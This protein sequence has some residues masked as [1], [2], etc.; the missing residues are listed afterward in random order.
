MI[1]PPSVEPSTTYIDPNASGELRIGGTLRPTA[2]CGK[3]RSIIPSACRSSLSSSILR[4]D[5]KDLGRQGQP[6]HEAP[7]QC[8][9]HK[10]VRAARS[11][12]SSNSSALRDRMLARRAREQMPSP[13]SDA[14]V[15]SPNSLRLSR[16]GDGGYGL[17]RVGLCGVVH[18]RRHRN[19][20]HDRGPGCGG[21]YVKLPS[22]LAHKSLYQF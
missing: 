6:R 22:H 5:E 20:H 1:R 3:S 21:C 11:T 8:G 14:Q 16:G 9:R 15:G 12:H 18:V 10:I 7:K 2:S 19:G 17:C 13:S 4:L